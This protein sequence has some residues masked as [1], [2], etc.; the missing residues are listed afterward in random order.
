MKANSSTGYALL[1][2]GIVILLFTFYQAYTIFN[3]LMTGTFPLLATQGSGAAQQAASQ[4]VSVQ[5]IVGN[6]VSSALS[7]LHINTYATI[8]ILLIVL[9]LFASIGYKFAK[10]GVETL[11][12]VPENQADKKQ[13]S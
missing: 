9:E 11:K 3:E 6:A 10:I 13:K 1:A 5:Q 7:G 12:A 2:V 8:I 4:N